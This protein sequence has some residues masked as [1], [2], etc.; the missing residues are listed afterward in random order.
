MGRTTVPSSYGILSIYVYVLRHCQHLHLLLTAITASAP[1]SYGIISICTEATSASRRAWYICTC[2]SH[3]LQ[4]V[5]PHLGRPPR[6]SPA[7]LRPGVG[8]TPG[9][10]WAGEARGVPEGGGAWG[11][12]ARYMTDCD[13]ARARRH[14]ARPPPGNRTSRRASPRFSMRTRPVTAA[15]AD[16]A[17]RRELAPSST[18]RPRASRC[19]P[20][21][22]RAPSAST[23]P[24]SRSARACGTPARPPTCAPSRASWSR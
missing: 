22:A 2:V 4:R 15:E 21:S 16:S 24:R 20:R 19:S 6:A 3:N 1:T 14:V 8:R 23:R 5:R 13:A 7:P 10:I 11:Y 9:Q 17:R 18:R 12:F